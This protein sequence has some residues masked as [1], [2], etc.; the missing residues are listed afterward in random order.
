MASIDHGQVATEPVAPVERVPLR[1]SVTMALAQFG[2]MLALLAP[3]A[4]SLALKTQTLVPADR[5]AAVNGN[6]LAVAALVALLANPIVGRLS[7][8]TLSRW[9]RRR[10]WMVGGALLLLVA[11]FIVALAGSIPVLLLGWCLAQAGGNAMLAPLMATIA[12]HVPF[13]QRAS[14]SANVGVMQNLGTLAAAFLA[15]TLVDNLVL[16][17][18]IPAVVA[19]VTVVVYCVVLPDRQIT[20]RP[21]TGGWVG[22]LQSFWVNPV[23]HPDFGWAWLSRFLVFLSFHLFIS[24]RLFYIQE[25][26]SL[27]AAEAAGILA[28]S[29]TVF[30]AS[31]VITAKVGGMLSDRVGRRKVFVIV[32]VLI[33]SGTFVLLA[34][35]SSVPGFLWVEVL[36][37]FAFGTYWAV[38]TALVIEVLPNPEHSAKDLGV[39]N[40][41]NTLPQS[42]AAAL[43]GLLLVI[44]TGGAATNYEALMGG[45]AFIGLLGALAI[46][47]IRSV[48]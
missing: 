11:M 12:D 10:P 48:R 17:F 25:Q 44:G 18:V 15:A 16:L 5:A 21:R 26:L 43:G 46:I 41:A 34:L 3:V 37:G 45:A 19:T 33:L 13:E 32:S 30:T 27:S 39:M 6:V 20:E 47:P 31:L 9:G 14:V 23:R 2:V 35:T 7:D 28:L 38:D 40:I 4:V 29:T 36:A 22:L 42:L 24:F 8:L 1:L